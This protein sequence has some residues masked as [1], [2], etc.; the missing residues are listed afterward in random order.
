MR[1]VG[2]LQEDDRE[3]SRCTLNAFAY[4]LNFAEDEYL[5]SVSTLLLCAYTISTQVWMMVRQ[6]KLAT[7]TAMSMTLYMSTLRANTDVHLLTHK[8]ISFFYGWLDNGVH[9]VLSAFNKEVTA[10]TNGSANFNQIYFN[11]VGGCGEGGGKELLV[12]YIHMRLLYILQTNL[13]IFLQYSPHNHIHQ[14][15]NSLHQCIQL[16]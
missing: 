8:C 16:Y 2:A 7:L 13:M 3:I 14:D 1:C 6:L 11:G 15:M 4:H 5:I 9:W 12:E 10:F